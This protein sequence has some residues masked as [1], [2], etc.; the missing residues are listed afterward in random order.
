MSIIKIKAMTMLNSTSLMI[1][2]DD[3]Y[4]DIITDKK[5]ICTLLDKGSSF[6]F[7]NPNGILEI[8]IDNLNH[9]KYFTKDNVEIKYDDTDKEIEEIYV[10]KNK[11]QID[12]RSLSKY[13]EYA[14]KNKSLVN[15]TNFL[16]RISKIQDIKHVS[17]LL[18]FMEKNTL[19]ITKS[20]NILGYKSLKPS[21]DGTYFT[22]YHTRI[23]KQNEGTRVSMKPE[24]VAFDK[25]LHCSYGLH[26]ATLSYAAA[27]GE[28][29]RSLFLVQ[30]NPE[31]VISVPNDTEDKMRVSAYELLVQ[32]SGEEYRSI[33]NDSPVPSIEEKINKAINEEYPR[34]TTEVFCKVNEVQD[35]EDLTIT[36]LTA[37]EPKKKVSKKKHNIKVA[38]INNNPRE[39][40]TLDASIQIVKI[41]DLV[42]KFLQGEADSNDCLQIYGY[43][44]EHKDNI[45]WKDLGITNQLRKRILRKAG[46]YKK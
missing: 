13:L 25:D 34:Y 8:D 30:I 31:D 3:N 1:I 45:S 19:P 6:F 32:L 27:F 15:F 22:D 9:I 28:L 5:V 44:Q 24:D 10:D 16:E 21:D 14:R 33:L 4:S 23:I 36:K 38:D 42:K 17:D 2:K 40:T 18:E 37:E 20:G 29:D 26:V 43:Y 12:P 41:K 39:E 7:N 35:R 46:I 11:L